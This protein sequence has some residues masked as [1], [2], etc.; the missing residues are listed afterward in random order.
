M[1]AKTGPLESKTADEGP[2]SQSLGQAINTASRAHHTKLNR[3][4]LARLPLALPPSTSSPEPYALG[5]RHFA[6]LYHA[7][8]SSWLRQISVDPAI[9]AHPL[10]PSNSAGVDETA[11]LRG[12]MSLETAV[13][14]SALIHLRIPALLRTDAL[15]ED[16]SALLRCGHGE[17]DAFISA[18]DADKFPALAG[19]VR[20]VRRATEEKPHVLIA[21]AWVLNM[22][23][24]NGGRW[25]RQHLKGAREGW[26]ASGHL[27]PVERRGEGHCKASGGVSKHEDEEH[28]RKS[29]DQNGLTFWHF[30]GERDGEDLKDE[31]K[32]RLRDVESMLT[33]EQRDEIVSEAKIVFR[34][35]V[36]L[37]E[38]LDG[39]MATN[40]D[41]DEEV[42]G[43]E[44]DEALERSVA[45]DADANSW[46]ARLG[47]LIRF[48]LPLG[49]LEVLLVLIRWTARARWHNGLLTGTSVEGGGAQKKT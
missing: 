32:A 1:A 19:F 22:A 23:L 31:F 17:V 26:V 15:R 47:L 16:L 10:S 39:M 18:P 29:E 48:M 7:F 4:V 25:I 20:H 42:L 43:G 46:L 27:I 12:E 33:D 6:G 8:E 14:L 45:L 11:S 35:C 24:F 21:Y 34:G 30:D 41:E 9:S 49:L 2:S 38:E 28:R 36:A 13:L 40:E 3:L 44:D 5:L 37:V